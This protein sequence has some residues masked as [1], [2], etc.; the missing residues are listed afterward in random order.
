M[1]VRRVEKYREV[2]ETWRLPEDVFHAVNSPGG[3]EAPIVNACLNGLPSEDF[4]Q[5]LAADVLSRR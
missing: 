5:N 1:P 2:P 4:F 3:S